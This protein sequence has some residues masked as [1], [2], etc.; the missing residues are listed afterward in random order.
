MRKK[1][2]TL[3]ELLVVISIIALL[4][5]IMIPALSKAKEMAAGIPCLANQRTIALAFH[6]YQEENSGRLV[7][8]IAWYSPG[9]DDHNDRNWVYS[10]LDENGDARPSDPRPEYEKNGI[11]A[12]KLWPYIESMDAYHCP[13]DKR[14]SRQNVGWRSYSMVN[15]IGGT[16]VPYVAEDNR[17]DKATEIKSPGD[18][19]ISVEE[20]E[21]DIDGA[22]SW[23][24]GGWVIDLQNDYWFDPIALWHVK[25]CNLAFADGHAEKYKWKDSRTVE[26]LSGDAAKMSPDVDHNSPTV[27]EDLSYMLQHYLAKKN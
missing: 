27:S 26:W 10:P 4:L 8:S 6:L 14:M 3:I 1:A 23:N 9:N 12:G 16:Y 7:S 2:F 13:A 5:S 25:G 15:A 21:K 11:K 24:R 22:Y 18:K 20:V 17:I 19:Y